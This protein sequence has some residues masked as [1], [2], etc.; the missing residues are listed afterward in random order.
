MKLIGEEVL[1]K[2][3]Y[4]YLIL[5]N[6]D[7]I[8]KIISKKFK[9]VGTSQVEVAET[10][11]DFLKSIKNQLENLEGKMTFY[12]KKYSEDILDSVISSYCELSITYFLK[13]EKNMQTRLTTVFILEDNEWKILNMHNSI[14]E[15]SQREKD[16]FPRKIILEKKKEKK[17]IYLPSR[18]KKGFY[19]LDEI[20]WISYSS[21]NRNVIFHLKNS[22]EFKLKR[23][24]SEV[25]QKLD[26]TKYFYKLDRG[27]II[28][29]KNIEILDFNEEKIYFK[30]RK[31]VYVSKIKLK[32]I[33]RMWLNL[34]SEEKIEL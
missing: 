30:N 8:Q 7:E 31:I 18:G 16:I 10:R 1:K 29:L 3:F 28:N 11:E 26:F 27:T 9:G 20:N 21:I 34:K 6:L 15:T 14:G 2:F 22:E 12:I 25:K 17:M 5:N 13:E 33:E 23:N 4:S 32:E 19:E 24:F